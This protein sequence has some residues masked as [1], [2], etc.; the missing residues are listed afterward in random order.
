LES[1][2]ST[3]TY[4]KREAMAGA[5]DGLCAV[6]NE[7]TAGRGRSGR[8]FASAPDCGVYF[9]ILMR[10]DC[11]PADAVTLTAHTAV[12]VCRAL[13]DACGVRAGI[14]WTNDIVLGTHKICGILTEMSV[15]GESG[16]LEYVVA[17]I[18]VNANNAPE[19]FPPELRQ[20]AGSVFSETGV[21][22]DRGKLAA[23]LVRAMDEMYAAWQRD[24]RVYLEAYR[25]R[26]V[27]T[28]RE[29][30]LLRDGRERRAYAEAVT[31]DF[32]LLVRYDDGTREE[33]T[34]GEVSVRGLFGYA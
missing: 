29:V 11:A 23:A 17:G 15:E 26:C 34:S 21:R 16:A 13:E 3:N 19:D 31:D 9:S 8:S 30:R 2:D 6:A 7:Q 1:V 27:T 28:G 20:I 10:P 4:L 14:K 22:V 12:A 25:A 33:I 24:H 32:G 18:G 5:A